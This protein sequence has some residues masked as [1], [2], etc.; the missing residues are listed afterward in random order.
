[1]KYIPLVVFIFFSGIQYSCAQSDISAYY[2][3]KSIIKKSKI[4]LELWEYYSRYSVDS[5]NVIGFDLLLLNSKQQV[6]F[7]EAVAKRLLGCYD[8]RSGSLKNGV[9]LLNR[10]K[11]LFLNIGDYHLLSEACN[12]LGIAY[13]L[14]GDVNT[15]K[16]YFKNSLSFGKKSSHSTLSYMAEINLAKCLV[17]EGDLIYSKRLTEHYIRFAEKDKKYESVANGYSLLGQIALDESKFK[18]AEMCFNTQLQ[19][20]HKTNAPLITTRAVSNQAI[21]SFMSG[22]YEKSLTLFKKVL[23]ARKVQGFHAYTCEAYMNLANFYY[24]RELSDVGNDYIDSCYHLAHEHALLSHKIE[25]LELQ[26]E[27]VNSD[28]LTAQISSLHDEQQKLIH[29]NQE[30]RKSL[31]K[32]I[33]TDSTDKSETSYLYLLLACVPFVLWVIYRKSNE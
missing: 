6:P 22:Q 14:M 25:A 2:E 16:N 30:Q 33:V 21:L 31:N 15:A 29:K 1:M 11:A 10:S 17:Q 20:A 13:L 5:L 12:E 23:L 28:H 26:K 32:K 7:V 3:E 18:R 4:A 24:Q 27:Y 9:K 19:F 8:I